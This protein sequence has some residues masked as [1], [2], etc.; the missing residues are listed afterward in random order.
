MKPLA[1]AFAL[2]I[3]ACTSPSMSGG[4]QSTGGALGTWSFAPHTC[5][6]GDAREFNGV[7]L[8]DGV[9]AVRLVIDPSKGPVLT[10][11][12]R[13]DPAYP[14]AIFDPPNCGQFTATCNEDSG[15][16]SGEFAVDC[17]AGVGGRIQGQIWFSDCDAGY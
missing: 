5:H 7:D 1:C 14:S 2:A 9:R 17:A 8:D 11:S 10:I 13:D 6:S 15:S 4:M 3:A 12:L 16:V